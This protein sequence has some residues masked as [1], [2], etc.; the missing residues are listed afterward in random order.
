[1]TSISLWNRVEKKLVFPLLLLAALLVAGCDN[2]QATVDKL[3][4]EIAEFKT[5]PD[6]K[7]QAA[8]DETFAKL[9]TKI[10]E[11][12]KRGDSKAEALKDQAAALRSDYQSAK[13]A[14]ALQDAK[15]AIQGF[16]EALK[17]GAKSIGDVFKGSGTNSQ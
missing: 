10:A 15:N 12:E 17:D 1:M 8:I 4:K 3:R 5:A 9:E 16:G 14:R 2:P 13:M 7:K 6:D 11:L